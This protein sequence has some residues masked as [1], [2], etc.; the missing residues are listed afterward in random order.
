VVYLGSGRRKEIDM[1]PTRFDQKF[2]RRHL[3][4]VLLGDLLGGPADV[5]ISIVVSTR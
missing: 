4:S 5:A 1:I 2:R 3:P